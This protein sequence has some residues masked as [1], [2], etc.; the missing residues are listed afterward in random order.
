MGQVLL[1][2]VV[3]RTPGGSVLLIV[4][5]PPIF[6]LSTATAALTV[7]T[8]VTLVACPSASATS[9]RSV[10]VTPLGEIRTFCGG[11]ACSRPYG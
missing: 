1:I 11:R 4:T 5:A 6:A 9:Y 2:F 10:V 3:L 8:P 7:T